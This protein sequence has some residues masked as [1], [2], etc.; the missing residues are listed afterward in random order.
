MRYVSK[1]NLIDRF[2]CALRRQL[3]RIAEVIG[4]EEV[5]REPGHQEPLMPVI[6]KRCKVNEQVA[7]TARRIC[8]QWHLDF[9][10]VNRW[11]LDHAMKATY[12]EYGDDDLDRR[13]AGIVGALPTLIAG[14][15]IGVYGPPIFQGAKFLLPGDAQAIGAGAHPREQIARLL[16]LLM[17]E[18][19]ELEVAPAESPA[20]FSKTCTP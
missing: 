5:N 13:I 8:Y 17:F 6:V 3:L 12:P 16:A 9:D 10:A 20:A 2:R 7:E 11:A 14:A 15:L 19:M 4:P 18:T 1:K